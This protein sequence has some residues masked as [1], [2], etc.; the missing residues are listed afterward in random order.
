MRA[1]RGKAMRTAPDRP[2]RR[3]APLRQTLARHQESIRRE[4]DPDS[5]SEVTQLTS[6][7]LI[8]HHIYPEAPVFTPDGRWF[9]YVGVP[10]PSD[11]GPAAVLEIRR[12]PLDQPGAPSEVVASLEGFRRPYPL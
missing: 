8:H 12:L 7:A 5:G 6:A 4:T 1:R 11:G 10:E 2:S 3:A 9:V